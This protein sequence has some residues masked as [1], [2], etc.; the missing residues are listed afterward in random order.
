MAKY[1][2][3]AYLEI[4][5]YYEGITGFLNH[6]YDDG[7]TLIKKTVLESVNRVLSGTFR[8]FNENVSYLYDRYS[9]EYP[10][11]ESSCREISNKYSSIS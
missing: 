4:Y 9:E 7:Q 2:A 3:E 8:L 11:F 10:I 6:G 1:T 5:E